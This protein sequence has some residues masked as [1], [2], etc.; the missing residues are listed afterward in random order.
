VGGNITFFSANPAFV[1]IDPHTCRTNIAPC[2]A[3]DELRALV[4]AQ[5]GWV[6]VL[7]VDGVS[8]PSRADDGTETHVTCVGCHSVAPGGEFVSITDSYPSRAAL[9]GIRFNAVGG[10]YTAMTP[11]GLAALQQPGW[12]RFSYAQGS[13]KANLW[14]TGRKIGVA[15]LGH[16]DP[17]VPD[18]GNGPD[19]NDSPHL[20]W[21]NIEAPNARAP[22]PG[23]NSN[24]SYPSYAPGTGVDSGNA[25]G[26]LARNGDSYGAATPTFSH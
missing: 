2:V 12:G 21:V 14:V 10:I 16:R 11:G 20:A 25:L 9:A 3:A 8:Q 26:F 13:G 22:Q 5:E 6:V 15:S 1:A 24:W 17:L 19:Q 7:P 4:P 23:D 18:Y